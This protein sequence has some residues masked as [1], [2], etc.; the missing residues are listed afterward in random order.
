MC[1]PRR[2]HGDAAARTLGLSEHRGFGPILERPEFFRSVRALCRGPEH[3]LSSWI[4]VG[5]RFGFDD[6]QGDV[7]V[8]L[9][10]VGNGHLSRLHQL[11][12]DSDASANNGNWDSTY[13]PVTES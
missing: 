2:K 10:L 11:S 6:A 1:F 7:G 9:G 5:Y 12:T 8:Q 3:E 4:D 13:L